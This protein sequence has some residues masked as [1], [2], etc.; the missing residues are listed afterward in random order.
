M[1][2]TKIIKTTVETYG[3]QPRHHEMAA[4][5]V[6]ANQS[7]KGD[8]FLEEPDEEIVNVWIADAHSEGDEEY[9]EFLRKALASGADLF[10]LKEKIGEFAQ[11]LGDVAV[12]Y[13]V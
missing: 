7:D 13:G 2:E 5:M 11:P 9:A 12:Y 6:Y 1:K 4:Q 10:V 3:L 8:F